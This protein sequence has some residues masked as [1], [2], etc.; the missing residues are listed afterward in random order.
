[1]CDYFIIIISSDI[2]ISFQVNIYEICS[3]T[4][5]MDQPTERNAHPPY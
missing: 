2:A 4:T 5:L 1:M 3:K